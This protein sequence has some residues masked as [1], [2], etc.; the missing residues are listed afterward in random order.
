MEL[1]PQKY[2]L[3]LILSS[4]F[5]PLTT[6][7][8][9]DSLR[10]RGF[11]VARPPGPIP[12]G[13]RVYL[14]GSIAKKHECWI[15]I[16]HNRNLVGCEGVS[17]ENTIQTFSE[18][19]AML[20]DDFSIDLSKEVSYTEL[21]ASLV[22]TS[23]QNPLLKLQRIS[24]DSKHAKEF[25]SVL[26]APVANYRLSI[27]PQGEFP[28][29]KKWFE[30]DI[31]PRLTPPTKAYWVEVVFRYDGI[32]ETLAFTRAL[33]STVSSIINVIEKS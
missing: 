3:N 6:P 7:D 2:K 15:D 26:G 12:V 16:D 28:S 21:T 18:L 19:I 5:F 4:L 17:L 32:E 20:K 31:T 14:S 9:F 24:M 27:V 33:N 25:G 13:P 23:D 8:V 22:V 29:S 11:E 1:K 30:I 10:S